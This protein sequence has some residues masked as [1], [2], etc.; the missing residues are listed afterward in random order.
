MEQTPQ[1]TIAHQ[2]A[3]TPASIAWAADMLQDCSTASLITVL[4][5]STVFFKFLGPK[6]Q[7]YHETVEKLLARLDQIADS[8]ESGKIK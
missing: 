2:P 1:V 6:L 4:V 3:G 8:Q 5:I 7:A